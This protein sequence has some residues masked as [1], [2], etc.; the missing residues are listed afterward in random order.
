MDQGRSAEARPSARRLATGLFLAF[1]TSQL[2]F[3][4]L[5]PTLPDVADEF[6]V[7]VG[8]AGQL[9][10]GSAIAGIALA[11][12]LTPLARR[13]EMR[14]LLLVGL[15]TLSVGSAL[16]GAAP[17]FAVLAAGQLIIGI[18]VGAVLSAG[19][20]AA[21]EWPAAADRKKVLSWAIVG[22]PSAWVVGMPAV[23]LLATLDWRW[24][25]ALV[26]LAAAAAYVTL[27]SARATT[28]AQS[29]AAAEP[30]AC[31]RSAW[32]DPRVKRWAFGELMAFAG[33]GGTLVYAGA[34]FA[35]SY[36]LGVDTIGILFGFIALSYFPGAFW[37]RRHLDDDLRQLLGVIAAGLA[38]AVLAFGLVRPA[39]WVSFVLFGLLGVMSG[40]RGLLGGAFGLNAAPEHKVAIGSIRT[41]ATQAG[42]L[43][44][45]G[46]GGIAVDAGGYAA[47]G[48]TL[49]FFFA[50]GV[51]PH[52]SFTTERR[53][54]RAARRALDPIYADWSRGDWRA[55]QPAFAWGFSSEFP[56]S[57]GIRD[58]PGARS[59]RFAEW[60]RPW[61]EWRVEAERF[62]PVP[63]GVLVET[64]YR[65][66]GKT[67]GVAVDTPGAHIWHIEGGQP[68]S[69][70][71]F[72]DRQNAL[73]DGC[74][75]CAELK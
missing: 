23:G 19:L 21:G 64:R 43:L 72:A 34:L 30:E 31:R 15:G 74:G 17:S 65:G 57:D 13:V 69:L 25:W 38:V 55:Q 32:R 58:E 5:G 26:P 6:G 48:A 54:V 50:L 47:V 68:V 12:V 66:V 52:L 1:F 14:G 70:E 71:V 67:S 3:V 18:G 27:P 63:C 11:L 8:T 42:Y 62:V 44:G 28:S 24:G 51:L 56:G 36:G 49:A 16:S 41:A 73:R 59:E 29:V 9:R 7:S 75:P 22:Q 35:D 60:L 4:V 37:A 20:A 2:A 46:A 61:K 10:T 53:M 40:A 45:A 33:W 39:V